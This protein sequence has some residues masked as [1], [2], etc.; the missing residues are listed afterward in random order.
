MQ[1]WKILAFCLLWSV[2]AGCGGR[3]GADAAAGEETVETAEGAMV[4]ELEERQEVGGLRAAMEAVNHV[5]PLQSPEDNYGTTYEIF[6]YSFYDS[7]GDGIGDLEGIRQKL[8]YVRTAEG[9]GLGA[10][11]LWLMPIHPSPSYH[12][13]DVED[14]MAIDPVYGDMEDFAALVEAANQRGLG[15]LLDVVMNHSAK[16]HPWFVEAE[17]YLRSL[18]A[19]AEPDAGQ[20]AYV[21]YY[22]FS[23]EQLEG[24]APLEGTDWYYEARFSPGMPDLNL[25]NPAVQAYFQEM[26]RF[27]LDKGAAGFR[28]DAALYYY[29]GDHEKCWKALAWFGEAVKAHNPR[30]YVVAEV[31]SDFATYAQY[32]QSGIDSMFNFAFGDSNG[33]VAQTVKG[34][35]TAMDFVR[36][37]DKVEQRLGD[38]HPEYI[39]A[40][41]YTNHDLGRGAG[42]YVGEDALAKSKLAGGLNL[43]MSGNAF[44]YYGEELAMKGSGRDENKRAPMP[45]GGDGRGL[46]QGPP[47]MEAMEQPYGDL[48]SQMADG[49]SAYWYWKEAMGLRGRHPVLARGLVEPVE[50]LAL[51]AAS[52]QAYGKSVAAFWKR[53]EEWGELLVCFNASDE[54]VALDVEGLLPEA[55]VAG[56]LLAKEGKYGLESGRLLLPPYGICLLEAA[57]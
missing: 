56:W 49:D 14:Y 35:V 42:Y 39:D 32:Y 55:R 25:D 33:L 45:W 40:P 37:M 5:R 13:Y 3:P 4:Q 51:D 7:D 10:D 48:E 24:Y 54:E 17:T 6:P 21:D 8:D 46:C 41:F 20:C 12:K 19:G 31:W 44:V 28:M 30:A 22:F 47:R 26:A 53:H 29:T 36:S 27:W 15:I 38:I 52:G 11:K 9:G 23:R 34:A 43:L 57:E 18:P 16:T 1:N 2:L 50:D